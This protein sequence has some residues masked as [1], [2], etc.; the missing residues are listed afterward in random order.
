MFLQ[1]RKFRVSYATNQRRQLGLS[2]F[3]IRPAS[4][5]ACLALG[6]GLLLAFALPGRA[7]RPDPSAT[8][9]FQQMANQN[10]E[11]ALADMPSNDPIEKERQFR[12]LNAERQKAMVSDAAKLLNLAREL[13]AEIR[14]TNTELLTLD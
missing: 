1:L 13:D 3:K 4:Q 14:R 10:S 6:F 9:P 2:Q 11:R 5:A 7:Q 12:A 8:P